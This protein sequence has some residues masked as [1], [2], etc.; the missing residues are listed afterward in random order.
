MFRQTSKETPKRIRCAEHPETEILLTGGAGVFHIE[1]G[2]S[3]GMSVIKFAMYG[4]LGAQS[5]AARV[6][7]VRFQ[8]H[9]YAYLSTPIC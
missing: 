3:L 6:K 8:L 5:N 9:C 7:A 2:L 1:I 4:S